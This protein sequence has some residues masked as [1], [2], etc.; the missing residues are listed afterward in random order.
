[1]ATVFLYLQ[2]R[3]LS[4]SSMFTSSI[5]GRGLIFEL[6]FAIHHRAVVEEVH[7]HIQQA[8]L[9][10]VSLAFGIGT[11]TI[12]SDI[13]LAALAEESLI[14]GPVQAPSHKTWDTCAPMQLVDLT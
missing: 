14:Q 5:F 12:D 9:V 8:L 3:I 7:P 11:I 4:T 6:K 13:T 10:D 1:M 2:T